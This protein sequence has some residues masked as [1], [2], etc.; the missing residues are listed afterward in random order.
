MEKE[1]HEKLLDLKAYLQELG[2]AAVAFS[3]GVDSTF[4]LKVAHD[5]LG[6][7]VTA[8]TARSVFVPE[9]DVAEARAFCENEGVHHVIKAFDTLG[10]DGIRSNP[11]N[12]CY[13][14]KYALFS[15]FKEMAGQLGLA[16]VVDGSNLDD[17]ADYRPGRKALAE[18][19]IKSPLHH[20]GFTKQDIRNLSREL[21]LA[22]WSKPSFACLA[23]RFVYGEELTPEKLR[24]VNKAEEILQA[25][26]FSQFRVRQHQ[27]LARIELLPADIDRFMAAD[28]RADI[29]KRFR[30][31][32][33]DYVT[34]DLFGYRTGSMNETLNNE[35]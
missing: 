12:R 7:A 26:G 33:F 27:S 5:T 14:C 1:L 6:D 15:Q 29:A 28:I 25:K 2:S 18:L 31:L 22:T 30:A 4:L 13:L 10:I 23:S 32:G 34:L 8:F 17:D 20:A 16:V 19:D 21:G 3:G 35:E 24:Q 11:T 9:R